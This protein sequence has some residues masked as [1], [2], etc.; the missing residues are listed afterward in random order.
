MS[1]TLLS[2]EISF[3][4]PEL[5]EE[6]GLLAVGG[7][8]SQERLLKAYSMGIFPWYSEDSPILWW[9]PDPRF[10]LFPE[11][12]HISRSLRQCMRKGLFTVTLNRA[13]GQVIQCCADNSRKDQPGTWITEAMMHAYI[14]LHHSGHACSVEAW[15]DGELAGGLYG[16]IL[17]RIFFG[18]S[19]FAR[20]N[21]A[22]KVAFAT[23]VE[24]MIP[25]GLMLI[26][27][28][29]RTEHLSHLGA[30]EIPRTDFL[31]LLSRALR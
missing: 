18:E 10:V 6:D 26:D 27:C 30:R 20:K 22:S 16:V 12:L 7:D 2:D 24:Q 3:P 13:F 4:P 11:E 19:M 1:I 14:Q 23:F 17:G 8:L 15:H 25:K 9:S 5:A 21:N 29:V 31:N 28:Q